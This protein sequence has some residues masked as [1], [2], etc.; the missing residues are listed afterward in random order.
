MAT[1]TAISKSL[2]GRDWDAVIDN[3]GQRVEWATMSAQLLKGHAKRY[4]YVSSTGVYF[5]YRGLDIREDFPTPLND[6]PPR[7]PP[8]YSPMKAR[9][10]LEVRKF[11]GDEGTIVV[12][13]Q[14]IV[15]PGD[16]SDRFP[17]WPV[18]MERGGEVLVPGKKSDPVQLIDVR[19][20]AEF[21]I[22]L[23][24][25][26]ASG[27]FNA[28]GPANPLTM[29][30]FIAGLHDAIPTQASFTWIENYDF[31][32]AQKLEYAIP[33]L[34][35]D[36][37]NMGAARINISR[38]KAAGLTFRPMKTTVQDTLEWWH[39]NAVP[40]TRRAK[41]RFVLT[42]EREAEILTAWKAKQG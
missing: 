36:A 9:S 13:P 10:E 27:V 15:G 19:D 29:D 24:E 40:E 22:R 30:R 38:A 20:L 35:P 39:S 3:S 1:A 32:K 17:Y 26:N 2:E 21:M 18:R 11:F 8:S 14:Y 28:A 41:P 12:R 42:P 6:D 23:V 33:W 31:L 7:E 16:P 37:D 5:P 34:M 4:L 25:K